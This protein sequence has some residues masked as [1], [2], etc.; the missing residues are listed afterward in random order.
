MTNHEPHARKRRAGPA[1][2]VAAFALVTVLLVVSL[3]IVYQHNNQ[4]PAIIVPTPT[5]PA[6]NAYDYF[7]R[8]GKLAHAMVHKSPYSLPNPTFSLAEYRACAEDARATVA[9]VREGLKRPMRQPPVRSIIT[10][11]PP[12]NAA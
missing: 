6:H 7:V 11:S 10:R 5:L 12:T 9:M 1:S 3:V 8:A 4:I 2:C